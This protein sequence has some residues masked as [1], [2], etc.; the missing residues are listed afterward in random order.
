M[1]RRNASRFAPWSVFC[2]SA[3]S[4]SSKGNSEKSFPSL[5]KRFQGFLDVRPE[6]TSFIHDPGKV[7]QAGRRLG[8]ILDETKLRRVLDEDA[9]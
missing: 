6:L 8:A 3:Q 2:R 7:G 1:A 4:Q 5:M 9:R